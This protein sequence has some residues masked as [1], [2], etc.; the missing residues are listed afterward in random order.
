MGGWVPGFS[1]VMAAVA[2]DDAMMGDWP[3]FQFGE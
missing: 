2:F 3:C 1:Y